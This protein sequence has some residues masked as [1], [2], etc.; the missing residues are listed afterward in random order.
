M[1]LGN[2]ITPMD[3]PNLARVSALYAGIPDRVPAM[4]VQRNCASGVEAIGQGAARIRAGQARAILAGGAESMSRIPLLFPASAG[5]A[6]AK[7]ARARSAWQTA[8]AVATLRPRHFK[9]VAALEEAGLTDPVSGLIMGKTAEILA[10]EFDISREE[11]D[12]FA[13]RS[14]QRA[15][16]A[17]QAGR[18]DAE[19]APVYA[20]SAG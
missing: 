3:A 12:A 10:Q 16:A 6:M 9:P 7:L 17:A 18:F 15:V 13:L 1:T 8:T 4:T 11:Q 20:G 14:H 2:V 5:E 19:I